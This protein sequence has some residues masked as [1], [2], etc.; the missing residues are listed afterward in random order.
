MSAA[1]I[2][3]IARDAELL[4]C[5]FCGEKAVMSSDGSSVN[6]VWCSNMACTLNDVYDSTED[7]VKA[8]TMRQACGQQPA[9]PEGWKSVPIKATPEMLHAAFGTGNE[10]IY[11]EELEKRFKP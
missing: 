8:W 5:P 10:L 3:Q 1:P 11:C 6:V 9:V 2:E 4:P 7:A